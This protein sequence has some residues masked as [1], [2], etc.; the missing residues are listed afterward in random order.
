VK[1]LQGTIHKK[2]N[3]KN[4]HLFLCQIWYRSVQWFDSNLCMRLCTEREMKQ[5]DGWLM[6]SVTGLLIETKTFNSV[7]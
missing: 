6:T 3:A 2:L 1:F 4:T 5:Y 7:L